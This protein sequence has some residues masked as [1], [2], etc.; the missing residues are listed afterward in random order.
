MA[1]ASR[2][3]SD[4]GANLRNLPYPGSFSDEFMFRPPTN[5]FSQVQFVPERIV[6]FSVSPE[7]IRFY[8]VEWQDTW[9]SEHHLMQYQ[10]LIEIFWRSQNEQ[11][12][13]PC[14][15]HSNNNGQQ[16]SSLLP[17]V[18]SLIEKSLSKQIPTFETFDANTSIN[19]PVVDNTITEQ[20][21]NLNNLNIESL[22]RNVIQHTKHT[23]PQKTQNLRQQFK[24]D[25]QIIHNA[26]G[27][28]INP[29]KKAVVA[30]CSD[31]GSILNLPNQLPN[32]T[33]SAYQ[34]PDDEASKY[35]S[36]ETELTKVVSQVKKSKYMSIQ[37]E[38]FELVNIENT[39]ATEEEIKFEALELLRSFSK[40]RPR[41]PI[42]T[43]KQPQ[44]CFFCNK[45]IA[46]RKSLRKHH[47]RI[48]FKNAG[49]FTCNF[50]PKRFMFRAQLEEHMITHSDNRNFAC[51]FC[52]FTCKR[53]G[54]LH[55]H[56]MKHKKECNYR[57]DVCHKNFKVQADLK[58]HCLNEHK[59]Q[60]N[61]C[62]VCKQTLQT[63]FSVYVHSMR[64][65]G[66]R[67]H[68]C[69]VCK[70]T[71]KSK[72]HLTT[73]MKKH[74]T[75]TEIFNCPACENEF[76]DTRALQRHIQL[77]HEEL[78]DKYRYE[79]ICTICDKDF[80][81]KG[82]LDKHMKIHEEETEEEKKSYSKYTV[83]DGKRKKS[84]KV[85]T[86]S[87]EALSEISDKIEK[88]TN[89]ETGEVK[90]SCKLCE[91]RRE[92]KLIS[93]M[94]NHLEDH[95]NGFKFRYGKKVKEDA[96]KPKKEK[97]TSALA[98]TP[99]VKRQRKKSV[100]TH[101][102]AKP[103]LQ[104]SVCKSSFKSKS[105]LQV[106]MKKCKSL[107]KGASKRKAT[108]KLKV[109]LQ[110]KKML[111]DNSSDEDEFLVLPQKRD[112]SSKRKATLKAKEK[113]RVQIED[114]LSDEEFAIIHS[115]EKSLNLP[116]SSPLGDSKNEPNGVL[117][118]AIVL[119]EE[120]SGF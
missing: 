83:K 4:S 105:V 88:I 12:S 109:K 76:P 59:N 35:H 14:A 34:V 82:W 57:C 110:K 36:N 91:S 119:T 97:D 22:D 41:G 99:K 72:H 19:P 100:T 33:A 37:L 5:P 38:G 104:C 23:S 85:E 9:L 70:A 90:L 11:S 39:S 106:H 75:K 94:E 51:K 62:N 95:K 10:N 74:K 93:S 102:P 43:A 116:S 6:Q 29:N 52:S 54:H 2:I 53:R 44:G 111:D 61:K 21:E 46:N 117:E 71:F 27:N 7:G 60:V 20:R 84:G 118:D 78:A 86:M 96:I 17:D 103:A 92:F 32:D 101:I 15:P 112:M 120:T 49:E 45:I 67:E 87:E 47:L 115:E 18:P 68:T 25:P 3:F 28:A 50:C 107:N 55:E 89:P 98:D 40:R 42:G 73:H 65:S 56:M 80:A 26:I 63:A 69:E 30:V 48:H 31:T 79:Y 1:S 16:Q 77:S 81:A 66:T 58:E 24:Q 108:L 13:A 8:K 113:L 64:H 114:A